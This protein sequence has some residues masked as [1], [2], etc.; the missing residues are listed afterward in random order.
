MV[1]AGLE[2]DT[3]RIRVRSVTVWNILLHIIW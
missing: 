3:Q 1:Q 2:P